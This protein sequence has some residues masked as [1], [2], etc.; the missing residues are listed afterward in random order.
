MP[1]LHPGQALAERLLVGAYYVAP[2]VAVAGF[3]TLVARLAR[4]HFGLR[5]AQMAFLLAL[6]GLFYLQVVTRSDI[7]HLVITLD[8]LFVLGGV[9]VSAAAQALRP[10]LRRRS[11]RWWAVGVA[12]AALGLALAVGS[13]WLWRQVGPAFLPRRPVP[14]RAIALSRAGVY[15]SPARAGAVELLVGLIDRHAPPDRAILALPYQPMLYFLAK[16]RNPTRWNYL[17]PGDQTADDHRALIDQARQDP[18]AVVV[19]FAPDEL[20][21]HAPVLAEY[22]GAH[23]RPALVTGTWTLYLPGPGGPG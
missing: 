2:V 19:V 8:P 7:H 21:G 16:R 13:G 18:P 14:S 15:T 23:Y 6:A 17:W 11:S 3:G 20:A 22:V 1:V 12:P 5:E 4:R 10:P 9:G